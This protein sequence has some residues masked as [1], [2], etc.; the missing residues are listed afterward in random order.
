MWIICS[1]FT[2]YT[3]DTPDSAGIL[4]TMDYIIAGNIA[5]Q[6]QVWTPQ[7]LIPVDGQKEEKVTFVGIHSQK[8][9]L[10]IVWSYYQQPKLSGVDNWSYGDMDY[11]IF[12]V[13]KMDQEGKE[14][15]QF[16]LFLLLI[17]VSY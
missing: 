15:K 12:C 3:P 13:F 6:L 17:C 1:T 16:H 4:Q 11:P 5:V 2:T 8:P 9:L 7:L 14:R 10:F